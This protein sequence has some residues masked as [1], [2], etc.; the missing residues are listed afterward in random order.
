MNLFDPAVLLAFSLS[1]SPCSRQS[2][3]GDVLPCGGFGRVVI[4]TLN[5]KHEEIT[6]RPA[7]TGHLPNFH[8]GT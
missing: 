2:S 7:F 1:L 3:F 6:G 8:S 4:R 5:G